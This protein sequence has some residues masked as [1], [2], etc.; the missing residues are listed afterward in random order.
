MSRKNVFFLVAD[1]RKKGSRPEGR[2]P[3]PDGPFD[4]MLCEGIIWQKHE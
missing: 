3:D 2:P 1:K 4:F